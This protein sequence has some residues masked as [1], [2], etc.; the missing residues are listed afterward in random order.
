MGDDGFEVESF[1][2]NSFLVGLSAFIQ[3]ECGA[4]P[5]TKPRSL[6][7]LSPEVSKRLHLCRTSH[8]LPCG[9]KT[10]AYPG[11]G[12]DGTID[13]SK[14]HIP[15]SIE[16]TDT[17]AQGAHLAAMIHTVLCRLET[18][19]PKAAAEEQQQR[20]VASVEGDFA[21]ALDTIRGHILSGTDPDA[22]VALCVCL[23]IL[24][25]ALFGIFREGTALDMS[26]RD[27]PTEGNSADA[28][29]VQEGSDS[30]GTAGIGPVMIL[31]D[32]IATPQ[33]KAALPEAMVTVLRLLLLPQGFNIR[34][35]VVSGRT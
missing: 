11:L 17:L 21:L 6:S 24:E 8:D 26:R 1:A 28:L 23:A 34:N 32:L 14:F 25:R 20:K 7:C 22:F 4:C 30:K 27:G 15:T 33:V 12:A 29:T 31:R 5:P 19:T 16:D 3:G 9:M 2:S 18:E 10:T 13:W 35:L